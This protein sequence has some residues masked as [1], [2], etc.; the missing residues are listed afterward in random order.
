MI[1]GTGITAISSIGISTSGLQ[2]NMA[3]SSGRIKSVFFKSERI[4]DFT[5]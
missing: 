3:K 5:N 1:F 4:Y 2:E